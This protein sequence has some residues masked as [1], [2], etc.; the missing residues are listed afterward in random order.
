M[1]IAL[2]ELVDR[3]DV[4]TYLDGN[5]GPMPVPIT[6]D[7]SGSVALRAGQP[8]WVGLTETESIA[9][10]WVFT[11]N[12]EPTARMARNAGG[13]RWV[14]LAITR[15]GLQVHGTPL[16]DAYTNGD[17]EVNVA[18]LLTVIMAWEPCPMPPAACHGDIVDSGSGGSGGSGVGGGQ[19]NVEDLL[20]VIQAWGA[21]P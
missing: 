16:C 20:A 6:T 10:A 9:L 19:V 3:P 13:T 18:D 15:S 5:T 12:M 2:L 14:T 1:A 7:F 11:F 17:G 4:L 8:N 21:C